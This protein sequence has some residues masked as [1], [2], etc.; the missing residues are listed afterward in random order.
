MFGFHVHE[1]AI[2][3]PLSLLQL[4]QTR[5][6][7]LSKLAFLM[8]L[9]AG[10]SLFP[11]LPEPTET[12][13]KYLLCCVFHVVYY[14]VLVELWKHKNNKFSFKW[15]EAVM[16]LGLIAVALFYSIG[17]PL[18]FK[19][20]LPF[21]PLMLHSVASASINVYVLGH[22]FKQLFVETF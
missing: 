4:I 16:I 6:I 21:V 17:H 18:I 3:I 15:F 20:R 1:K 5:N 12:L 11:L 14:A 7:T 10:I 9:N 13:I 2:L 22:L 19:N 8:S